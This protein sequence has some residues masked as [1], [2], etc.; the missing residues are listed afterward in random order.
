MKAINL[1][2]DARNLLRRRARGERVDVK[3]E[4]LEDYRELAQAGVMEPVSGFMRGPEAVFRFT[5]Q[6]WSMREELQ[7]PFRRFTPSAMLRRI[8]QAFSPIGESVSGA[9]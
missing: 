4:N 5:E 8:R 2:D 7:R 3:P 9:R 6:G 1:S